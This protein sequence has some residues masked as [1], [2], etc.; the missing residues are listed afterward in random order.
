MNFQVLWDPDAEEELA[1]IWLG[2][3]DRNA[4]TAAAH[5]ID[6]SLR[7]NPEDAGE[8]R[9]EQQR[10]LLEPPLGV[11][12]EVSPEDRTVLVLTVWQFEAKRG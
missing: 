12:F 7:V 4:I 1:A 2:A 8:S 11:T 3:R 6:S 9:A 10:V 5:R